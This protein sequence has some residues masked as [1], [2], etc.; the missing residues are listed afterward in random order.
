MIPNTKHDSWIRDRYLSSEYINQAINVIPNLLFHP[1]KLNPQF[2]KQLLSKLADN[3]PLALDPLD[4]PTAFDGDYPFVLSRF[5][6]SEGLRALGSGILVIKNGTISVSPINRHL[7]TSPTKYYDTLK[8]QI[9]KKG[10]TS[11]LFDVNA[12]HGKSSPRPVLFSGN[13][14]NLEI[15]GEFDDYFQ[16]IITISDD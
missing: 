12:L 1:L 2:K 10:N 4:Q 7:D 8:G 9:Y 5:N 13:M 15:K 6:P 11:V 16:L 3:Q 14:N